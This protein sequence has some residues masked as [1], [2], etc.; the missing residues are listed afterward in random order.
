MRSFD[1]I[2]RCI[3]VNNFSWSSFG[4]YVPITIETMTTLMAHS[5]FGWLLEMKIFSLVDYHTD[6]APDKVMIEVTHQNTVLLRCHTGELHINK[7]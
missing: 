1:L 7:I 2:S 6:A 4:R 5:G 3:C